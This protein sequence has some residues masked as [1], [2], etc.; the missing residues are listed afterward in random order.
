M[1]E[2]FEDVAHNLVQVNLTF[3]ILNLIDLSAI[4]QLYC[5]EQN[6]ETRICRSGELKEDLQ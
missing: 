6:S 1:V 2:H 4:I 5:F 3:N